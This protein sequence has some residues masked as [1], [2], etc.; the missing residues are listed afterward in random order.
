MPNACADAKTPKSAKT[1]TPKRPEIGRPWPMLL[2]KPDAADYIGLSVRAFEQ[3]V[4]SRKL[5]N[6]V[7]PPGMR[8]RLWRRVDLEAAVDGWK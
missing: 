4:A 8:K 7:T 2:A 1:E 5:P 3:F 6:A